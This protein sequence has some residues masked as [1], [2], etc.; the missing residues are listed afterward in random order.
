MKKIE[1]NRI[2][3]I[4]LKYKL[5]RKDLSPNT[6]VRFVKFYADIS[7]MLYFS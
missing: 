6:S 4:H 1:S 2:Q 3:Y 7:N 5:K